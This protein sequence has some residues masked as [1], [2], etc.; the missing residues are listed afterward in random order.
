MRA[1]FETICAWSDDAFASCAEPENRNPAMRPN[2]PMATR[3]NPAPTNRHACFVPSRLAI[4]ATQVVELA[5]TRLGEK[6]PG[7]SF[8]RAATLVTA[9]VC[10]EPEQQCADGRDDRGD[11]SEERSVDG[12]SD[13]SERRPLQ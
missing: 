2:M 9:P 7:V 5:L 6:P 3:M 11:A 4:V 10:E 1:R 12:G 13:R 8:S